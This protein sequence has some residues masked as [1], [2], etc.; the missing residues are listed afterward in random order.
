MSRWL[1]LLLVLLAPLARA[2][3]TLGLSDSDLLD[4][5]KA[6]AVTMQVTPDDR[7]EVSW[8]IAPG[9]YM[10][11]DRMHFSTDTPGIMLGT[12]VLP[13]AETKNDP[14]FGKL[15]IYHHQV[16]ARI[17][18]TRSPGAG[19]Q[20]ELQAVSQ[21]CADAGVC[22][23]PHTQTAKLV[24]AGNSGN[25]SSAGAMVSSATATVAANAGPA[26]ETHKGPSGPLG[27]AVNHSEGLF[28]GEQDFLDPDVAFQ[29]DIYEDA[30]DHL[31]V[32]WTIA[33]GYYLYK[34]KFRIT[35]A[36]TPG[37]T[38]RSVD[39]PGGDPKHD[40]FLGDV[41]VFHHEA[42][43]E[44]ALART[45]HKAQDI[46]LAVGYQGCAE[47]G[48]CYPPIKKQ[49]PVTLAATD[50]GAGQTLPARRRRHPLRPE[51]RTTSRTSS[52]ATAWPG[53]SCSSSAPACCWP[54]R[55]ACTR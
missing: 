13:P 7:A 16:T 41:T 1:P 31:R 25:S 9:Y 20:F 17:P 48:I 23:P 4:P 14:F 21:G 51:T 42:T 28:G 36:D 10:Y 33:N 2:A 40:Q 38:I 8:K 35:L 12:P 29:V 37:V 26:G 11:R 44:V 19:D 15:A 18:V 27:A 55:P 30:P 34:N 53:S 45:G 39:I 54:S 52:P 49:L 32:H 47:A 50:S 6:F 22:Y 46:T 43:A 24:L 3:D 5:D